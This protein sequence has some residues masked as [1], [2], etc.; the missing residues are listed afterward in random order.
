MRGESRDCIADGQSAPAA[1]VAS[2]VGRSTHHRWM[3]TGREQ[4]R[5]PLR[6]YHDAVLSAEVYARVLPIAAQCR[7]G[8]A[9]RGSLAWLRAHNPTW[10]QLERHPV[11]EDRPVTLADLSPHLR[12]DPQARQAW[13]TL[14]AVMNGAR[15]TLRART[16][17]RLERAQ[18]AN[19]RRR[20]NRARRRARA[21]P[22]PGRP[23]RPTEDRAPHRTPARSRICRRTTAATLRAWEGHMRGRIAVCLGGPAGG[24]SG[25]GPGS[26]GAAR[27]HATDTERSSG[28]VRH[29]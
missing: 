25:V 10:G 1:A 6:G 4:R 22:S 12:A 9:W 19:A 7:R 23:V 15:A 28:P 29:L 2:G 11:D 24:V 17:R 13:L 14:A 5:G 16:Q 8:D 26:G 27:R 20:L 3:A 18:R 21:G